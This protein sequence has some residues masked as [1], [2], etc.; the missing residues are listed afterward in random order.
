MSLTYTHVYFEKIFAAAWLPD[1]LETGE[2]ETQ[3]GRG[4]EIRGGHTTDCNENISHLTAASCFSKGKL[5][6][7]Q[8][9]A[10]ACISPA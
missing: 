7:N 6:Q 10:A 4:E 2:E 1:H 3:D 9:V 5:E 8:R